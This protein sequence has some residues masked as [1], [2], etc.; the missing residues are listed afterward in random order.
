[1]PK[2][3]IKLHRATYQFTEPLRERIDQYIQ[4]QAL[5]GRKL[6]RNDVVV[7]SLLSF[8]ART[9]TEVHARRRAS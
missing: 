7:E 5:V 2:V 9:H 4:A 3:P 1:M 6:S 8:F